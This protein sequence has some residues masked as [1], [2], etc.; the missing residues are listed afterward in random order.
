MRFVFLFTGIFFC[1]FSGWAQERNLDYYL[2]Q[3]NTHSPYLRD[4]SNQLS[5]NRTDSL[6]IR[7]QQL[8]PTVSL[9]GNLYYA[10]VINNWGYSEAITNGGNFISTLNISQPLFNRKSLRTG[11]AR[12]GLL[13]EV[14]TNSSML[15]GEELKKL[16][17][18]QY[19]SAFIIQ[20]DIEFYKRAQTYMQEE[21]SLLRRLA[22]QGYYSQT[23]YLSFQV[24]VQSLELD[25]NT[26]Q[27]EFRKAISALN[28]L[29]GISEKAVVMLA[30]PDLQL[31]TVG[32]TVKSPLFYRYVLDSLVIDNERKQVDLK[33]IPAVSWQADAGIVNNV[34]KDVY[35]NLGISLGLNFSLPVF[36]GKQRLLNYRKLSFREDS[37][38]VYESYFRNQHDE[39]VWQLTEELKSSQEMIPKL[40]KQLELAG[41]VI[42]QKKLLLN[43]GSVS[44]TDYL[45]ALRNYLTISNK[46]RQSEVKIL[47]IINEINYWNQ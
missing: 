32:E 42:R 36:D 25:L 14:I 43:N 21:D 10:P 4:L 31:K 11:Y 6:I 5:S 34:P 35:K 23:E 20:N 33:Y 9:T 39:Q 37:R 30:K 8:L 18:D 13:D 47:Q 28:I 26:L 44:M 24:E 12:V 40:T 45:M 38:K 27:V 22:E 41:T 2:D 1:L 15:A 17:T 46:Q 3:G 16:I 19:L 29:C 7:A